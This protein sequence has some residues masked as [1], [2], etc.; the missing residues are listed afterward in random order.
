[1]VLFDDMTH[2]LLILSY[3]AS[4][5]FLPHVLIDQ[6]CREGDIPYFLATLAVGSAPFIETLSLLENNLM[7]VRTGYDC[8]ITFW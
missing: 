5:R 4:F 6:L 8:R 1:M 7:R 3:P 2:C